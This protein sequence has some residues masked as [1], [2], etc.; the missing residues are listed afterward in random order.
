[1]TERE[2]DSAAVGFFLCGYCG[3]PVVCDEVRIDAGLL[4][5]L[6]CFRHHVCAGTDPCDWGEGKG[7]DG[8]GSQG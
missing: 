6:H 1:M 7:H 2:R 3:E 4:Y 8:C 5:H